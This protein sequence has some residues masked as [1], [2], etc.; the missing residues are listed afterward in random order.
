MEVKSKKTKTVTCFWCGRRVILTI[1]NRIRRI[2]K[3]KGLAAGDVCSGIVSPSHFSNIENSRFSPA[4]DTL[5]LIAD[6]LMVPRSY[7]TNIY[8]D[9]LEVEKRL[10]E[11]ERKI[12][13]GDA[14]GIRTFLENHKKS[15]MYISSIKQEM[16]FY[17][18]Y[19]LALVNIEAA[20][21]AVKLYEDTIAH[22]DIHPSSINLADQQKYNHISGLYYYYIKD[23][24]KSIHFF[25]KVLEVKENQAI[26]AKISFNIALAL[27]NLRRFE[28]AFTFAK[29]ATILYLRL[30]NWE[31]TGSCY[32]LLAFIM[33]EQGKLQES[34]E[35]IQKGFDI[36]GEGSVPL[37]ARLFHNLALIH[38]DRNEYDKAIDCIDRSIEAK[39]MHGQ[40]ELFLS[41]RVKLDILLESKD[42]LAFK[43]TLVLAEKHCRT[44]NDKAHFNYLNARFHFLFEDMVIYERLMKEAIELLLTGE[45]GQLLIDASEHFSEFYEKSNKYKK[46]LYYQKLCSAT[47]K[48]LVRREYK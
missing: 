48:K 37:Q 8:E 31:N 18:L 7:F 34:E 29:T 17:L 23:Y 5:L 11:L 27:S 9:S 46:A 33:R 15:L 3:V 47:L 20:N 24:E 43:R 40:S 19:F 44:G 22:F 16:Q 36:V 38:K 6:R 10:R 14:E 13:D 30:H 39:Q 41:L 1:G 4:P 12:E 2:R 26:R 42:F 32:N 45:S 35:Y 25:K 21:E 28:E